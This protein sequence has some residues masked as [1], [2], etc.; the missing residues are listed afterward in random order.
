MKKMFSLLLSAAMVVGLLAPAAGAANEYDGKTVVLYTG[1]LRGNIDVYDEIAAAKKDFESKGADVY[2]VDAG[3]FLQ[4]TA[5]AN[6]DRG[7]SIYNLM[8]AAGYDLAAMGAYE[9]T[10]GDATTGMIYHGNVHKYHTQAQL[11]EG[12]AEETYDV[13]R[14]GTVTE[15]LPAKAKAQFSVYSSNMTAPA[16]NT[17]YS[18]STSSVYNKEEHLRVGF[19]A[20]TDPNTPSMVQ[21][22]FLNG[23]S[24][25]DTP[26][27]P[28]AGTYDVLIG[29]SNSGAD[30]EGA[31][32]TIQAPTDGEEVVGAYV[33]DNETKAVTPVEG[34]KLSSYTGD[35]TVS[36][37]ITEVKANA[38]EVVATSDV[39][40][41]G[42]DSVGWRSETNLGDLV[43]DALLWYANNKFDGF[44][45]DV[46]VVAIQNGGNC[47]QFIYTGDIT[48][49]DLLRALP[50][51]PM[52]VGILYVTGAQL[53]E[54]LEAGTSPS[55]RYGNEVCPGF[56]QV[57]G[58][59]YVIDPTA[60]YDAGEKF[61]KF[62]K[63][64]SINR[65]TIL[66]VNGE[67]FD[68]A[69]TYAVIADNYVL[70]GNDTY[71]TFKAAREA[72]GVKYINNGNG[73]LT[74]NIVKMYI[75]QVLDGKIGSDYAKPQDRVT[76]CEHDFTETGDVTPATQTEDGSSTAVCSK[77]GAKAA[78]STVID[79]IGTIK[80]AQT[81]YIYDGKAKK[82]AVTVT[83]VKGKELISGTDYTVSYK[84]NKAAGKAIAT[85]TFQGNYA[86]SAE[87]TFQIKAAKNSITASNF[88]RSYSAKAQT[89]T[90]GAKDMGSSKLTY[91]SDNKSV[92]VNKS[93]GKVKIKEKYAGT[94]TIT[95]KAPAGNYAAATK[96][97]T[98][99][100]PTATKLSSVKN[101]KGKK[102]TVK[103]AQNKAGTGYQIQYATNKKFTGAKT[104]QIGKNSTK[105][106]TISMLKKKQKYSVR[107]RT[108]KKV[109]G[110][111]YYSNWSKVKTVAV[112]K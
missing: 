31:A 1:N 63:A 80:L 82:P 17:Y 38:A 96:K 60:E 41:N 37:A 19:A 44:E 5:Y 112:T 21:N 97:I 86:G 67:A 18:F 57:A 4:G 14:N 108:V 32:V 25:Y 33:I 45:K 76:F 88:T 58:L 110:K 107:I 78:G 94:A 30:V 22:V 106:T 74:R 20:L 53:L 103:W 66:S 11:Q 105:S 28:D 26:A 85:V 79:R 95:I 10:Y 23:Y 62:Y 59:N 81:S 6:S 104:I 52:G 40:L 15:T 90:I 98:I 2:L 34:F 13:N 51:S 73:V 84:N 56:A 27:L 39:T 87:T 102:L 35:S 48:E 64:D 61:G 55:A 93:T 75:Q 111:S 7:E 69:A 50:F 8:D 43:T 54:A 9:F 47:D 65:V 99:T 101:A 24:F 92:T 89:F 91:A 72:E 29:L 3:N 68:P 42:A 71:Y 109:S 12:A 46:P 70:N 49:T 100:V 77:C 36:A 83:D 16:E